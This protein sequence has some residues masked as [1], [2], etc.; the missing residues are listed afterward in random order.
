[1]TNTQ[2]IINN[3][4]IELIKDYIT[5]QEPF[6]LVVDN[7]N[8]WDKTLPDRLKAE[9]KIMFNIENTDLSDSY[10]EENGNI[11]IYVGIDGEVYS[12]I[13]TREDIHAVGPI[14]KTPII[15]KPF[16]EKP[17]IAEIN[18]PKIEISEE[19]EKLQQHSM[20]CFAKNNPDLVKEN[21]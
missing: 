21:K 13:L 12:K 8:N 1:M 16:V 20:K 10:V 4:L 6:S 3:A 7:H 9:K 14:K 2:H 18:V 15:M 17:A 11:V 19:T 5:N